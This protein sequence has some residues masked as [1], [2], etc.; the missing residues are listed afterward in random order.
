MEEPADLKD[1]EAFIWRAGFAT[2]LKLYSNGTEFSITVGGIG[3]AI[4][5]AELVSARDT[6]KQLTGDYGIAGD[7]AQAMMKEAAANSHKLQAKRY[8]IAFADGYPK[9]FQK[10][11]SDPYMSSSMGA[12]G[13]NMS[14]GQ[15]SDPSLGVAATSPVAFT[16]AI[17]SLRPS[18]SNNS[19]YNPDPQLDK[20]PYQAAQNAAK[21]GQKEVFDTALISTLIKSVDSNRLIDKYISDLI[22]GMD[23]IGRIYFLYLQHNEDFED[24][25][26]DDDILELEDNL[27]NTFKSVGDLIMFL[28]QK[29]VEDKPTNKRT[30]INF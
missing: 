19:M 7:I 23:R 13:M 16:E 10:K 2:P 30:E 4:K 1:V 12:P 22:M 29:T 14:M 17:P 15:S 27:R 3:S 24:R 26:G 11:A 9:F 5:T 18:M 21:T 20:K 28:K 6:L 8:S 25:Y